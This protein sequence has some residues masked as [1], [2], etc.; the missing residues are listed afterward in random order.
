MPGTTVT[1][2]RL[3][4]VL[5]L[6]I[7]TTT[8][9][10]LHYQGLQRPF[11]GALRLAGGEEN[12]GKA[13]DQMLR[14]LEDLQAKLAARGHGITHIFYEKPFIPGAVNS[15][16]SERLMGLCAVVQMFAFRIGATS[17]YSIDI[18]EWR[19]HFIGRG[20]GFKRTADKKHYLAGQD[21]KELAVQQ[22]ARYGWHTD[23]ADAAEA[24]GVLDYALS[25]IDRGCVEAGLP[26]YSRPWRDR[27]VLGGAA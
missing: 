15:S 3:G 22:C 12:V 4:T 21:P 23:I 27:L 17:C 5:A 13:L 1:E 24:C 6:D 9:W 8:G 7:A 11:F 16:T 19:K 2:P 10:A 25:L 18:S 26:G 20:S 14:F